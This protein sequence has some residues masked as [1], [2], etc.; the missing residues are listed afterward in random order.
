MN[1]GTFASVESLKGAKITIFGLGVTGLSAA[2]LASKLQT[3]LLIV[4]Q[5]EAD[6]ELNHRFL[7]Q[8]D[9]SAAEAMAESDLILLSPGIPRDHPVLAKAIEKSVPIWNEIELC[10]RLLGKLAP[11]LKWL[12]VTGTNGKTTTVSLLGEILDHDG[13]GVF[14]GGNIGT[15][16]SELVMDCLSGEKPPAS[17]VLELSS[18]QL[19]SLFKFRPHGCAILNISPSHGERYEHVRDYAEAK[20]RIAMNLG[21]GDTLITFKGDR[22]SEKVI[23]P[24][25]FFWDR[26]DESSLEIEG[27]DTSQF[28]P[29][30]RHNLV[31]LNFAARLATVAGASRTSIQSAIDSFLGVSHRLENIAENEKFIVLNDSK[32]TN[33]ASTLAALNSVTTDEKWSKSKITLLVGGK[34]RGHHDLPDEETIERLQVLNVEFILFGEFAKKYQ[35]EMQKIFPA[36]NCVQSFKDVLL[37][38]DA[39]GVLLFSPAFPS[40]DEFK[41]YADRGEHF[42]KLALNHISS[43]T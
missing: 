36:L 35:N 18:F 32:S 11:A 41:S 38:W 6:L 4:N 31:N 37:K 16:L 17:V 1:D 23:S 13:R 24:G 3:D 10:F 27:L 33:W 21:A 22:W 2:R 8:D 43:L 25:A 15:P 19:E 12:A 20:A 28:K 26:V 40:F 30:G 39:L 14:I 42:R 34:C 29:F 9:P 7:L 5:Q